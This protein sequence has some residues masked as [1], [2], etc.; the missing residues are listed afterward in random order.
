MQQTN[1]QKTNKPYR[2]EAVTHSKLKLTSRASKNT[3]DINMK[4]VNQGYFDRR[5]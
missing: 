5:Q 2:E 4:S 1:K 3:S